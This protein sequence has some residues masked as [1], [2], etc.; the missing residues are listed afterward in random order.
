M[1]RI[2]NLLYLLSLDSSWY[3]EE[4]G[5]VAGPGWHCLFRGPIARDQ[6]EALKLD[7]DPSDAPT[8]GDY[9]ALASMAGAILRTDG[10]GFHD[11]AVIADPG[12]LESEWSG[13]VESCDGF[14]Y[15]DELGH[16]E[17]DTLMASRDQAKTAFALFLLDQYGEATETIHFCS[18]ICRNMWLMV[19]PLGG[20]FV[21]GTCNDYVDGSACTE[22]GTMLDDDG[23]CPPA[24]PECPT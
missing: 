7:L 3:D 4:T 17:D 9:D 15:D 18:P 12:R 24:P 21:E 8:D 14:Y 2:T 22:C 6:V 20:S 23:R 13:I 19:N 16:D 11:S 10:Q 5:D 1:D